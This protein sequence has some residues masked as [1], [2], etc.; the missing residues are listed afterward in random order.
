M[1]HVSYIL[2]QFAKVPQNS[3]IMHDTPI[4]SELDSFHII[5]SQNASIIIK[6]NINLRRFLQANLFHGYYDWLRMPL[7]LYREE[8]VQWNYK[9]RWK[10]QGLL[11]TVWEFHE[12]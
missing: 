8:T 4:Q 2:A 3:S 1:F 6:A 7:L 11:R 10:H 9:D 12:Q 5:I